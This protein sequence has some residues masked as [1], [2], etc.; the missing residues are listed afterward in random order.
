M[1][2]PTAILTT[3][4]MVRDTFR[5]SLASKLFWVTAVATLVCVLLCLSISVHGGDALPT[6]PGEPKTRLPKREADKLPPD[7]RQGVD[8]IEGEVRILFGAVRVPLAHYREDAVRFIQILLAGGVADTLG[9]LLALIWTAGFLPTFLE[10]NAASVLMAKPVPRWGLL[11]GKYLGVVL[12]LALAAAV[13]V[14][15][16]WVALGLRNNVWDGTYLLCLPVLVLHFAVF[17]AFSAFLAVTTRST[18]ACAI[19]TLLFWL[20]CWGMNYGRH[21]LV[22]ADLEGLTPVSRFLAEAG[23]WIFPKPADFNQIL[24]DTLHAEQFAQKMPEL[25]LVQDRGAFV[26]ELSVLSSLAFAVVMLVVAGRQ[27][28]TTDY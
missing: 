7:K 28:A 17:F 11:A 24:F 2:L 4:L 13:F 18:A 16:T 10:P 12:F 6:S 15:G 3:R 8:V 22:A 23:Y 19:G 9:V 25:K 26:P 14:L 1:N 20:V 27:L 21:A 5:Q